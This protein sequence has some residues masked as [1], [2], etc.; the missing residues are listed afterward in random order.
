MKKQIKFTT[1][2]AYLLNSK[3]FDIFGDVKK[4]INKMHNGAWKNKN[5]HMVEVY[6]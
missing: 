1:N 5:S 3:A 4:F 6:I 2:T